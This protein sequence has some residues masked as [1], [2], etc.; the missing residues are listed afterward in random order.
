VQEQHWKGSGKWLLVPAAA[1]LLAV[2]LAWE[3]RY[4]RR[5]KEPLVEFRCSGCARTRSAAR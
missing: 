1:V 2:F 3:V 5:K 4:T